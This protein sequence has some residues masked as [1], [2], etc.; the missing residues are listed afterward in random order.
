MGKRSKG[1]PKCPNIPLLKSDMR[2]FSTGLIMSRFFEEILN[3]LMACEECEKREHLSVLNIDLD[4]FK[5]LG[6]LHGAMV[7]EKI[8]VDI[9]CRLQNFSETNGLVF[10]F[11]ADNFGVILTHLDHPHDSV[12]VAEK[13]LEDLRRPIPIGEEE[14]A[15]TASIG[16]AIPSPE[17][18]ALMIK[19][20]ADHAMYRAKQSGCDCVVVF[21]ERMDQEV[22]A[23]I[24]L[25]QHLR[26]AAQKP[27]DWFVLHYMPIVSLETGMIVK[28]EALLRLRSFQDKNVLLMPKDFIPIAERTGLIIPIGNWAL[29]K[30]CET[31]ARWKKNPKSKTISIS[32]NASVREV[33]RLDYVSRL[34]E[35]ITQSGI[36]PKLLRIEI[37]ET[38]VIS[39]QERVAK[40]LEELSAMNV[41]SL[42]DD[43]GAGQTALELVAKLPSSAIKLD[44]SMVADVHSNPKKKTVLTHLVAMGTDLDKSIISEGVETSEQAQ[45]MIDMRCHFAQGFWFERAV[46]TE[47]AESMIENQ[48][49]VKQ[50]KALKS[51]A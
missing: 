23:E 36:D 49:F 17:D 42:I 30:A 47:S 10:T 19:S 15:I 46:D 27:D 22:K 40:V 50:V 29:R 26:R 38:M 37:T 44:M 45:A 14:I 21:D 51:V 35:I 9:A 4:H 32:V 25:E 7:A 20:H 33:E 11:G 3:K 6:H 41:S 8:L 43:F 39:R 28:F 48:P 31:L 34:S 5:H 18:T 13:I 12:H 24:A 16:I 2:D 1:A